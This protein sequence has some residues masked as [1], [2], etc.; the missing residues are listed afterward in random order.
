[1]ISS[2]TKFITLYFPFSPLHSRKA[3]VVV[4]RKAMIIVFI[5][6]SMF[7]CDAIALIMA[8]LSVIDTVNEQHNYGANNDHDE[9]DDDDDEENVSCEDDDGDDDD[10]V[11]DE[12]DEEDN[13]HDHLL[14]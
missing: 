1:M 6:T 2:S 9:D 11:D 8:I 13:D 3:P 5:A 12:D 7:D 14:W 10:D 4:I